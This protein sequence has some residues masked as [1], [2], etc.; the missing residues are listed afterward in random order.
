MHSSA[1]TVPTGSFDLPMQ[2]AIIDIKL[3]DMDKGVLGSALEPLKYFELSKLYTIGIYRV[4]SGIKVVA[5]LHVVIRKA[6]L[7]A[8]SH[9]VVFSLDK[10]QLFIRAYMHIHVKGLSS[11]IVFQ[12]PFHCSTY[13]LSCSVTIN[14]I[15][16]CHFRG[17]I[18]ICL[19]TIV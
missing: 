14:Y 18:Y 12:H 4:L 17:Q 1:Y 11:I 9:K 16:G 19:G 6:T 5:Y 15:P 8:S 7:L 10:M 2:C 3:K 13:G